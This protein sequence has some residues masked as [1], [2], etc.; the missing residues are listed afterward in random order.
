MPCVIDNCYFILNERSTDDDPHGGCVMLSNNS[1]LEK[2][3][4]LLL[5][6]RLVHFVLKKKKQ[7]N[8]KIPFIEKKLKHVVDDVI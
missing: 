5:S 2:M 4:S 7:E 6:T 3:G 8:I 1:A